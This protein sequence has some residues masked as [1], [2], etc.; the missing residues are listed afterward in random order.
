MSWMKFLSRWRKT[1][2]P[3][4]YKDCTVPFRLRRVQ[5]VDFR[6]DYARGLKELLKTLATD[7]RA[8]QSAPANSS[9]PSQSQTDVTKADEREH[10]AEEERRKATEEHRQAEQARVDSSASH[11]RRE[12][13]AVPSAFGWRALSAIIDGAIFASLLVLLVGIASSVLTTTA[14]NED[15]RLVWA[16]AVWPSCHFLYQVVSLTSKQQATLGMRVAKVYVTD[17]CG[18]RLSW[19][20][21]LMRDIAKLLTVYSLVGP[22]M[23]LWTK[24][25]QT[26]HDK[27][28]R[29]VVRRGTPTPRA[30]ASS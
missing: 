3:V 23:P 17:A 6:Q 1:V 13:P 21:A 10:A 26:I 12:L 9:P 19:K 29:S 30:Q 4:I 2:I 25:R 15:V 24:R 11:E 27:V 16:Y 22:F 5:Y 14:T 8:G 20:R 28:A 18:Q 7:Q